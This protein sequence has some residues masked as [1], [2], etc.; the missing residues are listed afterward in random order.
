LGSYIAG[1]AANALIREHHLA[2]GPLFATLKQVSISHF[3][4]L[5]FAAICSIIVAI[6]ALEFI[7]CIVVHELGHALAAK[8]LG[9]RV[10][11]FTVRPFSYFPVERRIAWMR[12]ARATGDFA[13]WVYSASLGETR[14]A[15]RMFVVLGGAAANFLL[16]VVS[17]AFLWHVYFPSASIAMVWNILTSGFLTGRRPLIWFL[18]FWLVLI[19]GIS[20]NSV[21]AGISNLIPYWGDGWRSDGASFFD[22][23]FKKREVRQNRYLSMLYSLAVY[24]A[25]PLYWGT[26]LVRKVEEFSGTPAENMIRDR[27]LFDYYYSLGDV[28]RARLVIERVLKASDAK[29]AN[30]LIEYAFLLALMDGNAAE[31]KT[32]LDDIP[33]QYRNGFAFWRAMAISLHMLGDASGAR[34]AVKKAIVRR[35]RLRRLD[36]DDRGWIDAIKKGKPLPKLTPRVA[37]V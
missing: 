21:L 18:P 35:G 24:G 9:W 26:A 29:P 30:A 19:F 8:M 15:G 3:Y 2:R 27:L 36:Q 31:A 33:A 22:L 20:L 14:T 34:D 10:Y 6:I 7:V 4:P 16:A 1:A 12:R 13:G 37:P 17:F 32:I 23:L 11:V 5:L 28:A 25:K